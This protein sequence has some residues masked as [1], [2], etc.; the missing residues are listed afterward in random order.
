MALLHS[1]NGGVF[2]SSGSRYHSSIPLLAISKILLMKWKCHQVQKV[3]WCRFT[4]RLS[5]AFLSPFWAR[6]YSFQTCYVWF[7]LYNRSRKFECC[8]P[9]DAGTTGYGILG[10][11]VQGLGVLL[12]RTFEHLIL[13]WSAGHIYTNTSYYNSHILTSLVYI[14][15]CPKMNVGLLNHYNQTLFNAG[16]EILK[17]QKLTIY[18]ST[19]HWVLSNIS[20]YL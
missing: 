15:I 2:Y 17:H 11:Y 19:W 9:Y 5:F 6:F 16:I 14:L 1:A 7:V 13:Q 18:G 20:R 8:R 10:H 4:V 3:T 12:P